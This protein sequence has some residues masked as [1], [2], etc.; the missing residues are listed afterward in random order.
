[1]KHIIWDLYLNFEMFICNVICFLL[2]LPFIERYFEKKFI[3]D[4]ELC[5]IF[6]ESEK[7]MA[8]EEITN[9][10]TREQI[11]RKTDDILG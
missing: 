11:K 7:M 5:K 1:M 4:N 3:K 8:E 9:L 2:S 6:R 10:M